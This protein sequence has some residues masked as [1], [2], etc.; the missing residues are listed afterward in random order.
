MTKSV[1][2]LVC[3]MVLMVGAFEPSSASAQGCSGR[4]LFNY[5]TFQPYC[6]LSVFG[7][8]VCFEGV[9]YC[10]EFACPE[11]FAAVGG[12]I[13]PGQ[14]QQASAPSLP[15]AR[16]EPTILLGTIKVVELKTRT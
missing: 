3:S 12:L 8:V 1:A 2:F 11:G 6:S 9:D 16:V 10:A 5:Q 13:R 7:H 14:C 4:C 15:R